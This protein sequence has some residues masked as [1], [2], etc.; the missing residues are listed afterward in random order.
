LDFSSSEKAELVLVDE[1]IESFGWPFVVR[2]GIP[3]AENVEDVLVE[4]SIEL[5]LLL[6][7]SF[8]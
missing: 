1:R 8:R 3:S 7:V 6:G 5:Q 4:E 2:S